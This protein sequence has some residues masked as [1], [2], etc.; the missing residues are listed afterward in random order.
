LTSDGEKFIKLIKLLVYSIFLTDRLSGENI[1]LSSP[2]SLLDSVFRRPFS[3]PSFFCLLPERFGLFSIWSHFQSP[4]PRITPFGTQESDKPVREAES[5]SCVRIQPLEANEAS[6]L[7]G[8]PKL[9]R[10]GTIFV[11]SK[12][13]GYEMTRY[14]EILNVVWCSAHRANGSVVM[15]DLFFFPYLSLNP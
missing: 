14:S 3:R 9:R 12:A 1:F 5:H 15:S 8:R 2:F 4:L 7:D 6:L 11:V 10:L 13:Q